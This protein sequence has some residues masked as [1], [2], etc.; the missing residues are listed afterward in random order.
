MVIAVMVS[1]GGCAML[2]AWGVRPEWVYVA[3]TFWA[4]SFIG[5]ILFGFGMSCAGGCG[6]G[7]CWRLAE[8]G[9]KQLIA[10]FFL[11]VSNS[12]CTGIIGPEGP[13]ASMLGSRVF[14]PHYLSYQWS[15][16]LVIAV[17]LIFYRVVSWNE[18]T[19]AFV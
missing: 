7:T 5:G 14:L 1:V 18:K 12:V 6:S 15:V 17:L 3:P 8:G 11:G 4:G 10:F 19:R 16:I 2:K 13:Y 9:V